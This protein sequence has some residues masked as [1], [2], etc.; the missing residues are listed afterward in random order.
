ML[1]S[2]FKIIKN[3]IKRIRVKYINLRAKRCKE[4]IIANYKPIAILAPH[5]D[6]EVLGCAGLIQR[7]KEKA[8]VIIL[9]RGSGSHK[10][11]C[12][13]PEETIKAERRKLAIKINTQLGLPKENLHVLDYTD[14][15]IKEGNEIEFNKLTELISQIRPRAIFFPKQDG[16]G[17]PDHIEAGNI[18]KKIC[19][20]LSINPVMYE[21]CVWFW[22]YN[23]WRIDWKKAFIL[24]LTNEEYKKKIQAIDDYTLP[25]APC[26]KPWSGVLPQILINATKWNKELYFRSK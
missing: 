4:M 19:Q 11:C 23:V 25:E 10:G 26:G 16:E 17:W 12:K 14:G 9:T 1:F 20:E 2:I 8:H 5:P 6:D 21:Y 7:Y 15:Y 22:Y 3:F 18:V 24:K 13:E